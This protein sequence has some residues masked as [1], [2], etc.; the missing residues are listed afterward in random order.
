MGEGGG[1]HAKKLVS[2]S[3]GL[4]D[5]AIGLV[6]P[7]VKYI[8]AQLAQ[9]ASCKTDFLY[10]LQAGGGEGKGIILRFPVLLLVDYVLQS[11]HRI[12][13]QWDLSDEVFY[14]L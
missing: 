6:N 3:A 2:D 7:V 8:L 10:T 5:F 12:P 11:V 1:Q 13:C 14:P 4:V 9:M